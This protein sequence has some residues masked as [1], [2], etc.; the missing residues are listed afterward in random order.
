MREIVEGK[1]TIGRTVAVLKKPNKATFNLFLF[2]A[3][4]GE[5]LRTLSL[6]HISSSQQT[7]NIPYFIIGT[8]SMHFVL[9]MLNYFYERPETSYQS[10]RYHNKEG[11]SKFLHG[12]IYL[13]LICWRLKTN[14]LR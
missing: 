13:N 1:N 3:G 9:W 10:E 5:Q 6:S 14:I 4:V 8:V 11:H 2:W 7:A 12:D